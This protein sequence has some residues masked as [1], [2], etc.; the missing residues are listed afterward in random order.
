[1]PYI[2]P[3]TKSD[4]R[5]QMDKIVDLMLEQDVKVDGDLNYILFSFFCKH[6]MKIGPSY[7]KMKNFRG[8]LMEIHDHIESR[9]LVYYER[10]KMEENGD[11]P[12]AEE[13]VEFIKN[14]NDK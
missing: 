8:E 2:E 13:L 4:R 1:M 12:G 6:M 10:N 14:M 3:E 5:E 11:V 7:N 9:F